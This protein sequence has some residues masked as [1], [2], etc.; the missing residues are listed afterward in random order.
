MLVTAA[1]EP[2]NFDQQQDRGE[3]GG[4]LGE[5]PCIW[6]QTG[7][8]VQTTSTSQNDF[9]ISYYHGRLFNEVNIDIKRTEQRFF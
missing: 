1:A 7:S 4:G 2:S 9:N 5:I 8:E 6:I 3:G